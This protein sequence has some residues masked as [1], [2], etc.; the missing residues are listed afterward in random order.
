MAHYGTTCALIG[1]DS[2]TSLVLLSTA[3]VVVLLDR[4][5]LVSFDLF[6]DSSISPVPRAL[7]YNVCFTFTAAYTAILGMPQYGTLLQ[8]S[9]VL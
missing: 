6:Y 5:H 1:L 8:A 4:V 3:H 7:Y 9:T 2:P